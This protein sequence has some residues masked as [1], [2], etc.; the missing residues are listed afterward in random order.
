MKNKIDE[1]L[2]SLT[3]DEKVSLLTGVGSMSTA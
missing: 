1:I 2:S 3:F